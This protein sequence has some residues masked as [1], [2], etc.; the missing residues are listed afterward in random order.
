MAQYS[1]LSTE[2]AL[3]LVIQ[4]GYYKLLPASQCLSFSEISSLDK[5]FAESRDTGT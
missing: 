2:F 5:H 4:I 3:M 1:K